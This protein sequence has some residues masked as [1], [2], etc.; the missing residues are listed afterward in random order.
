SQDLRA[1]AA[2]E[3][4]HSEQDGRAHSDSLTA[5]RN[6]ARYNGQRNAMFSWLTRLETVR[7][8]ETA[9]EREGVYRFRYKVYIEELHYNLEADH[10]RKWLKQPEDELPET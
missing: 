4:G 3:S 8:A 2:H 7:V 6:T 9:P 5:D 1:F 10:E